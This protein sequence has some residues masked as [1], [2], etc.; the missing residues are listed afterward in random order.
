[1]STLV[2]SLL[3]V[4]ELNPCPATTCAW[5]ANLALCAKGF[6]KNNFVAVS[7]Y[8]VRLIEIRQQLPK[9]RFLREKLEI[10]QSISPQNPREWVCLKPNGVKGR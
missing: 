6:S 3:Y 5:T 10:F 4:F 8:G 9:G 2:V 7:P 1:L